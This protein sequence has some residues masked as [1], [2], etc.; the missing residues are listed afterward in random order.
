MAAGH[1]V[2]T[3]P[4]RGRGVTLW[5]AVGVIVAFSAAGA[6]VAWIVPGLVSV[7]ALLLHL[8]P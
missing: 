7:I 2:R 4:R 1:L 6:S 5:N 8:E 3:R